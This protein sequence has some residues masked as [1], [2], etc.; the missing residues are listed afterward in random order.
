MSDN[1]SLNNLVLA[2]FVKC[3]IVSLVKFFFADVDMCAIFKLLPIEV[4]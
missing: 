4:V 2:Y 1:G 3:F